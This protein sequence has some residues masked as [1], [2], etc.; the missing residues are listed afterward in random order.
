MFLA[1]RDDERANVP[2]GEYIWRSAVMEMA[3]VP[4]SMDTMPEVAW[5]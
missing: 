4:E 3:V 5:I 2:P 1:V